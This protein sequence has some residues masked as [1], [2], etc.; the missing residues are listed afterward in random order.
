MLRIAVFKL[1][2]FIILFSNFANAA[3]V[4]LR[5]RM[6]ILY[7]SNSI[8]NI[9]EHLHGLVDKMLED[10]KTKPKNILL[11][12]DWDMVIQKHQSKLGVP[13]EYCEDEATVEAIN[14]LIYRGIS[15]IVLTSRCSGFPYHTYKENIKQFLE[16][17][18]VFRA[19]KGEN[20]SWPLNK[21]ENY[22]LGSVRASIEEITEGAEEKFGF[23]N[24]GNSPLKS[25]FRYVDFRIEDNYKVAGDKID[26]SIFMSTNAC[27][28]SVGSMHKSYKGEGLVKLIDEGCFTDKVKYII[29][30]DDDKRHIKSVHDAF[31][32]RKELAHC[33]HYTK[34]DENYVNGL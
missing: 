32:E 13:I 3:D 26:E 7:S 28:V 15:T 31:K 19:L 5:H 14:E 34:K 4:D 1:F 24:P 25:E 22:H 11:A 21:G 29:F 6:S 16:D 12:L 8:T 33:V 30:I 20:K 18:N 23:G 17:K 9:A 2:T 10:P 27:V